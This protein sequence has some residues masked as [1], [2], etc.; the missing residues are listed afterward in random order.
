MKTDLSRPAAS[1]P[2]LRLSVLAQAIG[3]LVAGLA[4]SDSTSADTTVSTTG[5]T[6]ISTGAHAGETV[7]LAAPQTTGVAAGAAQETQLSNGSVQSSATTAA[8]AAGQTGVRA[9]DGGKLTVSGSEV[10]LD[11]KTGTGAAITASGL[12]G[13]SVESGAAV[14]LDDTKVVVGGGAKG[15]NNRGAVVTGSGSKLDM[16]GGSVDTSSW[17]AVGVRV[18]DGASATLRNGARVTTTGARSTATAGSHG[19]SVSGAGSRLDAADTSVTTSGASAYGLKLDNGA[20]ASLDNT[21][22]RTAGGNGHG[23][24]VDGT[25]S[26][27]DIQRGSIDTTGKGSVGVWARQGATATLFDTVIGTSGAALSCAAPVDDERVLSLSHA[28]FSTGIGTRIDGSGLD[29]TVAAGS[30]SAARAEDG[31][32]IQ[33]RDSKLKLSGAATSTATTAALHATNGSRIDGESLSVESIG[34]NVGGARAEGTGSVVS[35][36]GSTVAIG[37][38]GSI[39]NPAAAARAMAGAS[40]NIEDSQLKTTGM[41][42]HGV[43]VEGA[44]SQA[45]VSGSLIEVEGSRAI[46]VNVTGG[47]TAQVSDSRIRLG[48]APG[49]TG[50]FS[51]GV[52]VE[53]N[54]QLALTASEVHTTQNSSHG[55]SVQSDSTL[56][57]RGGK[58]TTDGNYSTGI[59]A[60]SSVVSVDDVA[61]ATH[62]NDNAM[63]IV[64]NGDS[65][66]T[67]NGGSVTTTGDGS[68]VA[69]N[70]T[71]P[72]ALAA[73][74]PGAVLIANGASL[75]TQGKQAYGAAADDGGSM[76]LNNLSVLTEGDYSR[77]L[78]AGIGQAKPGNV[79]LVASN[80]S[81][82]TRGD[83]AA[84]AMVSR[85]FKD[86]TAV[87]A[88]D[89]TTLRTAGLQSHALQSESGASL[90][91]RN[92]AA[93]TTGNGAFGALASNT[94]TLDLDTANLVTAG[95]S[96][97]GA[98]AK[99]GGHIDGQDVVI[100]SA[101]DHAAALYLQGTDA[102]RGTANLRDAVL[103]NRSGATIAVAGAG[104]VNLQ[105]A[106]VGGSGE[107]LGV[108]R[109]M[110]SDGSSIPDMGTGQ[111][112]G[113]GKSY[114]AAGQ[115]TVNLSRS[116]VTGAARTEAGSHSDVALRDTSL[117][118][119]TADST[120]GTLRNQQSLIDFSAPAGGR[121]KQLRVENYEGDNGTVA[122]NTYLYTDN[123][124]SDQVVIDGG[125]ASGS[126]NLLV[127]NAA[128]PGA[129]TTG[130]GIKVVD[131]VNGGT[132]ETEAFRLLN[133]VKA[134]PYEYTLHRSS[135][136]DSN[137]EAWYLRST[138]EARPDDATPHDPGKAT[139]AAV[140]PDAPRVTP[141]YRAETSLYSGVPALAL[142]YG[143]SMVDTLHERIG[144][145]RRR[146][147]DPLPTED[148]GEGGPSMAWGRLIYEKSQDALGGIDARDTVQAVQLG[149]DLYRH[150]DKDGSKDHAGLSVHDGRIDGELSHRDGQHAGTDA[151]HGYGIGAY[152]THFWPKGGYLDGV[153]QYNR[154]K[155]KALPA[156][157]PALTTNGHGFTA[158]L[159]TGRPYLFG[160]EKRFLVEPQAQLIYSSLKLHDTRDEAADVR[161][162][163]VDSLTGRL[164]VRLQR[165]WYRG[166]KPEEQL[167]TTTWLRPSVWHEFRGKP[168]TEFSSAAGYVPFRVDTGG[169]WMELNLGLD[170]QISKNT[171]LTGSLGY[172]Q[173]LDGDSRGYGGMI[174]LK[175]KF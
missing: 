142:K 116:V 17:G 128:G 57:M 101:G 140:D 23:V 10:L 136:D 89:S 123:S 158:S 30:A 90:R 35:L 76:V 138:T 91:A 34:A 95:A 134:G 22:I 59:S 98:V 96:A 137:T 37:G 11:P 118:H 130:N 165:E 94:G 75:H 117:W 56:A 45:T 154:L 148:K 73:R 61:V 52:L 33:L 139:I 67:V 152:W 120:L 157:M 114:D 2:G 84:G 129:L 63:G 43:S 13:V 141:N 161:F 151:L 81:V 168:V 125:K 160:E 50:P 18:D 108:D 143:R 65:R 145:Q 78:Y 74:N 60:G 48:A 77:G 58:V 155:V 122:L 7:K 12:T 119:M 97:H 126:T 106:I 71:F 41:F 172:Q 39:A 70:L 109:A 87:M 100:H 25:G 112:Q 69:S 174:G 104:D 173:S 175:M 170:R 16:S 82:E 64:A 167:R 83:Q 32:A 14:T 42:G 99:N 38:G 44:G 102:Q 133:R 86:E 147:I 24:V 21:D 8:Q 163:Q 66:V 88:L 113:V 135:Q 150:E 20:Q 115:A 46:G 132:T 5:A 121:Y 166:D 19:V 31:A 79:S 36:R 28:L 111:W 110:A 49:A 3:L 72:H 92:T 40:V 85:Q 156:D 124:P 51:P 4:F 55:V 9:S 153:L 149:V 171:S 15:N 131:A 127:R 146:D 169:T 27:V 103:N 68:P 107:W 80:V 144:E 164:G 29:I 162:S 54:S 53:K 26:V 6:G 47:A 1:R 93:A 62:G 159:E 105:N